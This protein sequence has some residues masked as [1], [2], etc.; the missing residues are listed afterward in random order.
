MAGEFFN[1]VLPLELRD[2]AMKY[3][4]AHDLSLAQL[5]RMALREFL[6]KKNGS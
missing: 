1:F 5:V 2:K 6:E 3:A 4:V